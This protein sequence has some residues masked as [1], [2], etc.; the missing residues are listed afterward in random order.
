MIQRCY[1]ERDLA[2]R[3]YGKRG[4]QVEVYLHSSAAFIDWAFSNGYRVGLSLDRINNEGNYER[5]NLRWI[6]QREQN[7]N[8]RNNVRVVW[9]GEEMCFTDFTQKHTFLSYTYAR[10]LYINGS[11]LEELA[12]KRPKERGRRA[13]GLRSGKL[14]PDESVHGRKFDCP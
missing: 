5:T 9:K 2:Y 7:R 3:E 10:K 12:A 6:S 11:T 4:I 14:R 13:Q 8:K 1:N